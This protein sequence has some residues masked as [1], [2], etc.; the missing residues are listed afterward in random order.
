MTYKGSFQATWDLGTPALRRIV[1]STPALRRI[2]AYGPKHLQYEA[3]IK[4][5]KRREVK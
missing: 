3:A 5:L 2:V 4:E 1:V